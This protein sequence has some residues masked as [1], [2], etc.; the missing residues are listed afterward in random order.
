HETALGA[1]AGPLP[2]LLARTRERV[3]V[4]GLAADGPRFI[5]SVDD[6]PERPTALAVA[7]YD[8]DGADDLWVG[9]ESPGLIYV[10]T[11]DEE[12][13]GFARRERV[14]YAWDDIVRILPFNLD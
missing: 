2:S 11:Y 5:A 9:T 1:V 13:G 3:N 4:Y 8:G 6:L 10:F 14:G 12:T 7:D